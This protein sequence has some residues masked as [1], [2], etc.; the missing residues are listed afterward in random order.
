[1]TD[2]I[3]GAGP[4]H[5]YRLARTAFATSFEPGEPVPAGAEGPGRICV[6]AG[7]VGRE[8]GPCPVG[9]EEASGPAGAED[10]AASSAAAGS[11]LRLRVGGGPGHVPA[12]LPGVGLTGVR[13]LRVTG[14]AGARPTASARS[15][16][17][18]SPP[19]HLLFDGLDVEI[20]PDTELRYAVCPVLDAALT[21]RATFV[22]VDCLLD[23]GMWTGD[24]DLA[25]QHGA[26]AAARGQGT[27]RILVP[28]HWNLVRVGLGDRPGLVGRRVVALAVVLDP[29]TVGDRKSTRLN[30]SH[31]SLSRMPSS[32]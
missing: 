17:P 32:A 30:S 15:I 19:R 18:V 2:G 4:G 28:D 10:R 24:L 8:V 12:G 20:G 31:V 7:P 13:A 16:G 21:Y 14:P 9:G 3:L 23:D 5:G 1:M 27:A 25:D 11:A 6:G 26:A 22:S 29:P